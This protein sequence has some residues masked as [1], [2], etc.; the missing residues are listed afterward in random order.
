LQ[1]KFYWKILSFLMNFCAIG[2]GFQLLEKLPHTMSFLLFWGFFVFFFFFNI[3]LVRYFPHLHFQ[4][5]PKSPPI[6]SHTHT[7][8]YPPTS[9][10]VFEAGNE[11]RTSCAP[12]NYPTTELHLQPHNH[13]FKLVKY[14]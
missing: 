1:N 7:L 5:Y 14:I 6:P 12:S 11:S 9:T 8:S 2:N 13:I 10:F 4:C 3:F